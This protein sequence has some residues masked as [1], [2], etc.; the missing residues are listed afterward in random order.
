LAEAS[1]L[2]RAAELEER[3]DALNAHMM[4]LLTEVNDAV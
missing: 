3:I 2:A 4:N 1:L